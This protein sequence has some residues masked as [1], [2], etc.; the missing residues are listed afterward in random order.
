MEDNIGN[1]ALDSDMHFCAVHPERDTELRCNRCDRYMCIDCA[2]RTPV[3]YTCRECVRGHE[4]KFYQGTL[5]DYALVAAVSAIGGALT[6]LLASL[7]GGFLLIGFIVSPAIGG[8]AAQ[9]ALQVTARRRGRQSGYVSAGALLLGGLAAALFL[10]GTIGI[11]TLI[12][13]ALAASASF[14]RFKMTI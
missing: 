2:K 13:L 12:Y 7:A 11:F 14:A 8:A 10:T 1:A 4:N 5:I 6:V 9:L 3:G